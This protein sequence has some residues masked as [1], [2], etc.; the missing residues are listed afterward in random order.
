MPE[1][2]VI[3]FNARSGVTQHAKV[4]HPELFHSTEIGRGKVAFI[5][6]DDLVE[7]TFLNLIARNSVTA[8]VDL[9]PRPVFAKPNFQHKRTV[10]YLFQRKVTYIEY[11]FA[12]KAEGKQLPWTRPSASFASILEGALSAGLTVCLFD[13]ESQSIG[14]LD[15]FRRQIETMPSYS[16]EMHPRSLI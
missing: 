6:I 16:A 10:A 11:A 14:W 3:Q 15:R 2:K 7:G 13:G 9:R 1:Q 5:Q 8:V 12:I 4:H